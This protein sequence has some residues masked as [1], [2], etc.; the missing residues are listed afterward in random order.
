VI[1]PHVEN[2]PYIFDIQAQ[3]DPVQEGRDSFNEESKPAD[4]QLYVCPRPLQALR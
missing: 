2:V 1:L 3:A 4:H